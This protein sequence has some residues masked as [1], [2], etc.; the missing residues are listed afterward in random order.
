MNASKHGCRT[1]QLRTKRYG[2]DAIVV[3]VED[4]GPG[5]NPADLNSIFDATTKSHGVGLELAMCRLIV[6]RHG[7][8]LLASSDGANGALFR[9]LRPRARS[10]QIKFGTAL[11]GRHLFYE[12]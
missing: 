8:R 11:Q 1:L 6:E 12:A 5:I 7:G 4:T 2:D 3:E 10:T 9:V